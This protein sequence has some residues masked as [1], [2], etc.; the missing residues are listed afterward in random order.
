MALG[1]LGLPL[2]C[3]L[4]HGEAKYRVEIY[5]RD[6]AYWG[7]TL[8]ADNSNPDV[9]EIIEIDMEGQVIWRYLVP[10]ELTNR[11]RHRDQIVM[12][13]QRLPNSNV[14]FNIQ[15][16]GLF[17]IDRSGKIVWQHQDSEASH[18]VKRLSNGHTLY[19][20]GWV[21]K[22]KPHVV[23]IDPGGKLIWSWDGLKHFDQPPYADINKEGWIH[24]NGAIRLSNGNTVISLRNFNSVIE[25]S[26]DDSLIWKQEFPLGD[27]PLEKRLTFPFH[28]HSPEILPNGNLLLSL[29]GANL[30]VEIDRKTG[31]LV[32]KWEYPQKGKRSVH[33]RDASRLANGNTLFVEANAITEL[34][35][36]GRPVWKMVVPGINPSGPKFAFLFKAQRIDSAS[37][38]K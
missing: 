33:I 32:W 30:I 13:V 18:D 12:Q 34:A 36:D 26:P 2:L 20:R 16:V 8:F 15:R 29:T 31:L 4:A 28:P 27:I 3:P 21:A 24:V 35:S 38:A 19:V 11:R 5:D 25:I 9:S 1:L 7:N 23:E 22:G 37:R 14:L 17:E 6:R 10:G